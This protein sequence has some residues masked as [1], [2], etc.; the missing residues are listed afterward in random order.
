MRI[1]NGPFAD[2]VPTSRLG[3]VAFG[4]IRSVS[5]Q[6]IAS[7]AGFFLHHGLNKPFTALSYW[8]EI[9]P[10]TKHQLGFPCYSESFLKRLELL[11]AL[12]LLLRFHFTLH[13]KTR[14]GL[15]Q[16]S[17]HHCL[18]SAPAPFQTGEIVEPVFQFNLASSCSDR[19]LSK[20]FGLVEVFSDLSNL[21]AS[22]R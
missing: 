20:R 8:P 1:V 2:L 14:T 12:S 19:R 5:Q 15:N 6:A 22:E 18:H 10:P 7:V 16:F 4:G 3:F 9:K 21:A 11:D 13:A 17:D